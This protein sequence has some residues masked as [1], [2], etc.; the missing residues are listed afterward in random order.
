M[1]VAQLHM[2]VAQ[3]HMGGANESHDNITLRRRLN[4]DKNSQL[5]WRCN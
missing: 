5:R 4:G 2:G 1:G 3:L